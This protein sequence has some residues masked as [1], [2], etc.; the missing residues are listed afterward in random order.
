MYFLPRFF[1]ILLLFSF[2]FSS[3]LN[4]FLLSD[5]FQPPPVDSFYQPLVDKTTLPDDNRRGDCR[6][7]Y[8]LWLSLIVFLIGNL[9]FILYS[10][11]CF[12]FFAFRYASGFSKKRLRLDYVFCHSFSVY[13]ICFSFLWACIVFLPFLNHEP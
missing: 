1:L 12:I 6:L 2:S 9:S 7:M 5:S 4:R 8:Y 13:F 3:L 11:L 10:A